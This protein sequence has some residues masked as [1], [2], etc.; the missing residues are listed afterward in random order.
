[1]GKKKPTTEALP[2]V[3]WHSLPLDEVVT[4]L[5]TNLETG[6]TVAEAKKRLD[7]FGENALP[8]KRKIPA[9]VVFLL[10]FHD[11]LIYLLIAVMIVC[12]VMQQWVCLLSPNSSL[13]RRNCHL[14][15]CNYQ[16]NHRI[17]PRIQ[18]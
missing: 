11:V 1:M 15:C 2:E 18:S 7:E 5:N 16:C 9:I 3:P 17:R 4:K 13:A 14:H 10:Q 8:K 6:L 12:F